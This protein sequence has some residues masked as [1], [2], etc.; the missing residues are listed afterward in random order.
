MTLKTSLVILTFLGNTIICNKILVRNVSESVSC[1][2]KVDLHIHTVHS[3]GTSTVKEI[4]EV[5][6]LQ[7]LKAVSITDHDC[8][9]AYPLAQELGGEV[10]IEVIPGVELSSEVEGTDIHILGYY[11]DPEN[12]AF[13]RKFKEMKDAGMFAPRR[14]WPISI[15]RAS[16]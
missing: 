11:I 16:I 9:D 5:A 4:V 1:K 7:G 14:L 10:G 8:T 15:N 2:K 3:D 13:S 12:P 6:Y